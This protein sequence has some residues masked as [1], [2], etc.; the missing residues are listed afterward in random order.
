MEP[1]VALLCDIIYQDDKVID[2]I[3]NYFTAYNDCSIR[4][5]DAKK[6]SQKKN[7]GKDTKGIS[8][9]F[10][11]IDKFS[12]GGIMDSYY[13]ASFLK[14]DGKIYPYGEDSAVLTYNYFHEKLINWI[15]NKL[16]TQ[17]D[18]GPLEDLSSY[19]KELDYPK[20]M[21][22]SIGATSYT[23]FGETGFL[24]DGDETFV[25]VYDKNKYCYDE[26]LEHISNQSYS[27]ENSSVLHQEVI[28]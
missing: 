18:E 22:I 23:K 19:I 28:A 24:K 2:I 6:I 4:K 13:I 14:R 27:L 17:K 20:N 11:K 10:I 8:N 12:N 9:Q 3:P 26:I 21:I 1:E 7:W 15:I 25:V 5:P 16:N